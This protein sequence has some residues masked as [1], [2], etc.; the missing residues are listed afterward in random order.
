MGGDSRTLPV[1]VLG[2]SPCGDSRTLG[3]D[4]RINHQNC[5]VGGKVNEKAIKTDREDDRPADHNPGGGSGRG[6]D[7]GGTESGQPA[8]DGERKGVDVGDLARDD[9]AVSGE[10][11]YTTAS[12]RTEKMAAFVADERYGK[13]NATMQMPQMPNATNATTESVE[14][15]DF[16]SVEYAKPTGWGKLWRIERNG[17]YFI[18]R[19]RF[20]D[21]ADTPKEYRRITR[22][23]GRITPQIEAK[24]NERKGRGRHA[25]SRTD[26][27]RFR[28]RA[29]DLAKRIRASD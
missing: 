22:K 6:A 7:L 16:S 26:A 9:G 11:P 5:N 12:L 13:A 14:N 23:G 4:D 24:F 1:S 2:V 17:N 8:S 28:S 15:V 3:L 21:S 10:M 27:D 18:Y 19:L 20:V 29:F 25:E